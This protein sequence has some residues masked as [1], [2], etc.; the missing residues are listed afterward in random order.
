[1]LRTLVFAPLLACALGA[2]GLAVAEESPRAAVGSEVHAD[3][4]TVIAHVTSV[5]RDQAGRITSIE[6]PGLEPPD[7]SSLGGAMVAQN[8]ANDT[9]ARVIDMRPRDRDRVQQT[10]S[11]EHAR[12]R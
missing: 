4:G 6:A 9:P 5:T 11:R 8:D 7:A 3:D 12:L 1:M 2:P 10:G